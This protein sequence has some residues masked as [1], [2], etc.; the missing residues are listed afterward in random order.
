ME[1][2]AEVLRCIFEDPHFKFDIEQAREDSEV[3]GVLLDHI[4]R[5]FCVPFNNVRWEQLSPTLRG[6]ITM[7]DAMRRK[8]EQYL[9]E[10][11]GAT[12]PAQETPD[13]Q[14]ADALGAMAVAAQTGALDA[15]LRQAGL[16]RKNRADF[17]GI[18]G[19]VWD[20]LKLID[21]GNYSRARGETTIAQAE[22]E[23]LDRLKDK[24]L[25]G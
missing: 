11:R 15:L 24:K 14:A 5:K 19:T 9:H 21:E 25:G 3:A 13:S 1:R 22:A 2:A 6:L 18:M 16:N 17:T 8:L 10:A 12:P 4:S 20:G 7:I 23:K